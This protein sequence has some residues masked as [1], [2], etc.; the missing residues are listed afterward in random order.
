MLS[1]SKK[2]AKNNVKKISTKVKAKNL[3]NQNSKETK[4]KFSS[5]KP[6]LESDESSDSIT[7][8]VK[9]VEAT[10]KIKNIINTAKKT[11]RKISEQKNASDQVRKLEE[12][13][14][15]SEEE[16]PDEEEEEEEED[17]EKE[18][19][20]LKGKAKRTAPVTK[21]ETRV[22]LPL[23]RVVKGKNHVKTKN[24]AMSSDSEASPSL[25]SISSKETRSKA[26]DA[27]DNNDIDSSILKKQCGKGIPK[28][29]SS[30]SPE[31]E[32]K[33]SS[34]G[35]YK[36]MGKPVQRMSQRM[37]NKCKEVF[38]E[39]L[40]KSGK[41]KTN[42]LLSPK[43]GEKECCSSDSEEPL[44]RKI[45][46]K[47]EEMAEMREM[48]KK[49]IS[50]LDI[51]DDELKK[52]NF[53]KK[54]YESSDSEDL[55]K[56]SK[57]KQETES[58]SELEKKNLKKST[59]KSKTELLEE[60]VQKIKKQKNIIDDKKLKNKK[61]DEK[62][63]KEKE[64]T[65]VSSSSQEPIT[66]SIAVQTNRIE[67]PPE[68]SQE[69]VQKTE[70]IADLEKELQVQV[71]ANKLLEVEL[72]KTRVILDRIRSDHEDE[73]SEINSKHVLNISEIKKKQWVNYFIVFKRS[74][75]C[76]N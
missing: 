59:K 73:I 48:F 49:Y 1:S 51:K 27:P 3:G 76:K 42:K 64:E 24:S 21:P 69:L 9:D 31:T 70:R 53:N 23:D 10:K 18:E 44:S 22:K 5:K 34:K 29:V 55:N 56:A 12:F 16:E 71:N 47:T 63:M 37:I 72:N 17:D 39:D 50:K 19:K 13:S 57:L 65:I 36:E 8:D 43:K 75:I 66:R 38:D 32:F 61:S 54:S 4:D 45:E 41:D 14:E 68:E 30:N 20:I 2:K 60:K 67:I 33:I 35:K 28:K 25:N 6:D 11:K 40:E 58:E 74:T 15:E 26:K 62:E 52:E 46:T 7:E